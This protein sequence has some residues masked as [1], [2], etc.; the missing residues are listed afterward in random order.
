MILTKHCF[1]L[2]CIF[3]AT[4]KIRCVHANIFSFNVIEKSQY[5][6]LLNLQASYHFYS[7]ANDFLELKFHKTYCGNNDALLTI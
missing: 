5:R 7:S 6:N 4:S 1:A 3:Q 2:Q